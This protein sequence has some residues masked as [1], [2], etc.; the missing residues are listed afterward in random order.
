M[1]KNIYQLI[2][3]CIIN[4]L[5]LK[6]KI[7]LTLITFFLA[8]D[9]YSWQGIKT[10]IGLKH[11]HNLAL[12]KKIFFGLT[13]IFSGLVILISFSNTIQQNAYVRTYLSSV[14]FIFYLS[15]FL[16]C[17]F[18]LFDD[19]QR[20]I[21]WIAKKKFGKGN[22][23]EP[24]SVATINRATFMSQVGALAAGVPLVLL[25]KGIFKGAYDYQVMHVPL[26]IKNLPLAFRGIKILQLSD[27]H[28]GSLLNRDAVHK[29]IQLAMAQ[30]P[31]MAFFTGDFV[32]NQTS[33]AYPL[34]E[35]FA[36]IKAPMGVHSILGNHDYGDYM[37]WENEQQKIENLQALY[38]VHTDMG[39]N[40]LR[41][42]H[43][44]IEKGGNRIGL[45]GVE[46]WG[47]K[48]RFQR[49]GDINKASAGMPEC[50]VKLLLSHDPSH[51]EYIVSEKY[52]DVNVTFSG[53]THGFQ[54]GVETDFI[55]WSPSKY[56]YPYWAGL[57]A[58][59]KQQIYVNRG[60]GFLGYPGRVGILPEIT[61]FELREA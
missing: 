52:N 41:N 57:Y 28:T 42:E 54:F 37:Q 27:I 5:S 8:I 22:L 49:Y 16:L 11:K 7:A 6:I 31:D 48:G 46:N 25:T 47:N 35:H 10:L 39:W 32:N 50:R 29:G 60:Y 14:V 58:K 4:M 38:Q 18:L 9:I 44:M 24:K 59:G 12:A 23:L 40:L 13:L 43:V 36:E 1:Q 15:K 2:C 33:E 45:I 3:I 56:I 51:F 30:K 34:M 17:I 55:K 61:I 26:Y 19:L 21:R 53:H 20:G